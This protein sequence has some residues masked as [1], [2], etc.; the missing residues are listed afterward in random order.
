MI[1]FDSY[2]EMKNYIHIVANVVNLANFF[3][4]H[5]WIYHSRHVAIVI[6]TSLLICEDKKKEHTFKDRKL[7]YLLV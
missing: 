3:V 5:Y 7:V 2:A 1:F 6:V 4:Y